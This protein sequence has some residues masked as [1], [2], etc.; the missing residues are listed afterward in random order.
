MSI[1]IPSEVSSDTYT[2][3]NTYTG[4]LGGTFTLETNAI[5]SIAEEVTTTNSTANTTTTSTAN[6]TTPTNENND[7]CEKHCLNASSSA[8]CGVYMSLVVVAMLIPTTAFALAIN[9]TTIK[10]LIKDS[11]NT[12]NRHD[13]EKQENGPTTQNQNDA[14][15]IEEMEMQRTINLRNI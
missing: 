12:Q 9:Y 8:Q 10:N 11:L 7:D 1:S 2:I 15:N 13:Y 6:T 3:T 4:S 5:I 14:P